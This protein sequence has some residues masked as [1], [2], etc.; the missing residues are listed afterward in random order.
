M[1]DLPFRSDRRRVLSLLGAG[2]FMAGAGIR[3]V[4]AANQAPAVLTAEAAR[5]QIPYGV[6]SGDVNADRAVIW[7]RCDRDARMLIDI[8]TTQSM[9]DARRIVGPAALED[10]DYTARIPLRD[11]APGQTHFYRVQ[12]QSL[13]DPRILSAPVNGRFRTPGNLQ[14]DVLTVGAEARY[15]RRTFFAHGAVE[16]QRAGGHPQIQ[17]IEWRFKYSDQRSVSGGRVDF[18]RGEHR[19]QHLSGTG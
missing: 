3:Q 6:M 19:V 18:A 9:R 13:A 7:S 11:L 10:S 4:I 5:P 8:A 16:H 1:S 2:G 15:Q 14:R 12:F 17:K